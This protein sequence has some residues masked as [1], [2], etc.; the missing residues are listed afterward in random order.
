MAKVLRE[1]Y[2]PFKWEGEESRGI[3]LLDYTSD[4]WEGYGVVVGGDET[5][6][7]IA[8]GDSEDGF[9]ENLANMLFDAI[10]NELESYSDHTELS[11]IDLEYVW[12]ESLYCWEK[13]EILSDYSYFKELKKIVDYIDKWYTE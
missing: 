13:D 9:S 12:L 4:N 2:K 11:T 5:D 6:W 8:F 7:T 3:V 10:V 1:F